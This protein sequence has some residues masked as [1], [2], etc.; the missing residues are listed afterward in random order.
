MRRVNVLLSSIG[1]RNYLLQYFRDAPSVGMVLAV[2]CNPTAPGLAEADVGEIVPNIASPTYLERLDDLCLRYQIDM[3]VPLNDLELPVLAAARDAFGARGVSVVVSSPDVIDICWDKAR[4]A[5]FLESIGLRYPLTVTSLDAA[6]E[7]LRSGAMRLPVVVKPRW[8]SGS[9]AIERVEEL[10]DLRLVSD[11]L[12]RKF[13]RSALGSLTQVDPDSVLLYQELIEGQE[14][15]LD[16]V[17]DLNGQHVATMVR[18]KLGMRAG[19]T[20][21]AKLISRH[22]LHEI[23]AIVGNN[24]RHCGNLDVDI[25]QSE[26]GPCVLDL[27]PRFG[28]G[29]PFSHEAGANIPEALARWFLGLPVSEKLFKVRDGEYLA[30]C[31]RMVRCLGFTR[32]SE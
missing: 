24:L 28:G 6:E 21:K 25:I 17:N 29:Y 16:V 8:G 7:K 31:D 14:Y 12:R 3:I 26:R 4:T 13:F 9:I 22:E 19:E 15:G 18:L 20:D 23:G 1:R 10:R 30:K 11:Y 5:H 27:N 2:D 32:D